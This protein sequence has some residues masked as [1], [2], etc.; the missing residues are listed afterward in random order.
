M[1]HDFLKL[2]NFQCDCVALCPPWGGVNY[3]KK[4]FFDLKKDIQPD[5]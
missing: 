1:N 4:E 3:F 2:P 5:F